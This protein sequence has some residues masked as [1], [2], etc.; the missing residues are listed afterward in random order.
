[1]RPSLER[2]GISGFS[3]RTFHNFR[4]QAAKNCF[5]DYTSHKSIKKKAKENDLSGSLVEI[6]MVR[7]FVISSSLTIWFA[8][9]EVVGMLVKLSYQ[10]K[11]ELKY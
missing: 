4:Y 5:V 1:M 2:W 6:V 10:R 7:D 3:S 9:G 11:L 8:V